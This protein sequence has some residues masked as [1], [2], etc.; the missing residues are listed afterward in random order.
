[1]GSLRIPAA[2]CGLVGLKPG[3]GTVPAG[4]GNGDWFGMSEN[5]PLATT[6]EDARL[7]FAVLAGTVTAVAETEAIRPSGPAPAR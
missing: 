5:G 6:V 1:M 2:N 7:M 4:I 3:Y